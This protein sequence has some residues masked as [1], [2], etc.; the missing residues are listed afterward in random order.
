MSHTPRNPQPDLPAPTR[1]AGLP[2]LLGPR[3]RD[4]VV[5]GPEL[6]TT[7]TVLRNQGAI[8]EAL[9]T[10]PGCNGQWRLHLRWLA[11]GR[12]QLPPLPAKVGGTR[13]RA[14]KLL[15]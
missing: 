15:R 12:C 5:N 3:P 1:Q 6:E 8:L 7:L 2:G 11:H 4:L 14:E 10:V 13:Q 9:E